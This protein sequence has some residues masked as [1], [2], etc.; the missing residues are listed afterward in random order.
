[1]LIIYV[2]HFIPFD[3]ILFKDIKSM[4][5]L[6]SN[7]KILNPLDFEF[8]KARYFRI[9]QKLELLPKTSILIDHPMF[10]GLISG[11]IIYIDNPKIFYIKLKDAFDTYTLEQEITEI[12]TKTQKK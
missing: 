5:L 4:A 11:T 6:P 3:I 10:C 1:M 2:F 9:Q 8:W 12:G 7:S